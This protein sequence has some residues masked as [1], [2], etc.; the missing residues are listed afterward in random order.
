MRPREAARPSEAPRSPRIVPDY[1]DVV[2]PPNLAPLNLAIQEPGMEYHLRVSGPRGQPLDLRRLT[3][4]SRRLDG[5]FARVLITHVDAAGRF[6]KP[7]LLP[8]E[9]PLYYD[10][11]LDNFN[12]PELIRGPIQISEE[13]LARA[14]NAPESG[15]GPAR[16]GS[17]GLDQS[18]DRSTN[19]ENPYP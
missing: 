18:A 11:C 19:S 1:V 5:V 3:F 7:L 8:Q 12:A 15:R 10:T 16:R 14:V 17:V 4:C 9:D 2:I 13:E 6:S